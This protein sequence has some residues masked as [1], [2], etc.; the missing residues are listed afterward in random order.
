ME[1]TT[2]V[3][4]GPAIASASDTAVGLLTDNVLVLLALPIAFVGY[5]VVRK[6]IAKIG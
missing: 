4:F 2:G 6:L 3:D 5:K 1:P